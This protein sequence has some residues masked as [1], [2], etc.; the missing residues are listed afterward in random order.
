[1]EKVVLKSMVAFVLWLDMA[2][3]RGNGKYD[4][5]VSFAKFLS[6]P[7]NLGMFV[8]CDLEGNV[9]EEPEMYSDYLLSNEEYCKIPRVHCNEWHEACKEYQEAKDR[10]LFEGWF[11]NYEFPGSITIKNKEDNF[12]G[13]WKRDL[14]IHTSSNGSPYRTAIETIEDL[15]SR[16]CFDIF[17]T[18]TAQK[19]IGL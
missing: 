4:K 15:L 6:Q 11:F 17:L 12:L 3:I 14:K 8:P 5:M 2:D 1:M 18:E 10:V 16:I 13:H 9:L 19:Q 7:L